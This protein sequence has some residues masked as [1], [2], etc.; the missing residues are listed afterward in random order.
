[1]IEKKDDK[2]PFLITVP[3]STMT[4]WMMEFA[5]WAPDIKVLTYKG[6]PSLRK[7]TIHQALAGNF[8]VMIT[9]YEYVI[10]DRGIIIIII[11]INFFP[12]VAFFFSN[13]TAVFLLFFINFRSIISFENEIKKLADLAKIEW[14]YIIVDEGHRIKNRNSKLATILRTYMSRHRL[15]LTGTPLQNDLG[16]LWAL[17]NFLLPS[18]FNRYS[19]W[20]TFFTF[21]LYLIFL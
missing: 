18:I 10:R 15:L 13:A 5:K 21:F 11:V 7:E 16:E 4:N 20:F 6:K 9:S 2:G 19:N 1:M 14:D 12:L 8:N 3:L 17:L